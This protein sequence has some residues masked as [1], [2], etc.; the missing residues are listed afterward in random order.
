[1]GVSH[2]ELKIG[3]DNAAPARVREPQACLRERASR[4][5]SEK[6]NWRHTPLFVKAR[7]RFIQRA[8]LEQ[9]Y[10]ASDVAGFLGCDAS[11]IS[12]VQQMVRD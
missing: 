1:M 6:A 8:I 5:P 7:R 9:G 10:K 12:R 3:P 11:T 2:R 4:R